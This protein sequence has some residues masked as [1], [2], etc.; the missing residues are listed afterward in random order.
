MTVR[1]ISAGAMRELFAQHSGAAMLACLTFDH[2]SM[3]T[4]AR[5]VNNTENITFNGNTYSAL[6]FELTLPDDI[7][8]KIPSLEI[9]IDNVERTLVDL[10]RSVVDDLPAVTVDIVRVQGGT[11]TREIGPLSLSLM[12]SEINTDAVT[13]TVGHAIDILNEPATQEIFNPGMAPGLFA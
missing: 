5:I 6:P 10:L 13:L 3:T 7:E 2:P 9:R 1:N 12:Q 8:D 4:P 11:V